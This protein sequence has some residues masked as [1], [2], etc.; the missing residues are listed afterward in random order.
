MGSPDILSFTENLLVDTML[1][2]VERHCDWDSGD[3]DAFSPVSSSLSPQSNSPCSVMW[4]M[5][6]LP[7]DPACKLVP[8]ALAHPLTP[9]EYLKSPATFDFDLFPLAGPITSDEDVF[10]KDAVSGSK[11]KSTSLESMETKKAKARQTRDALT[12][13]QLRI[14]GADTPETKRITHNVLERKRRNDLKTSYQELRETIPELVSQDR[15]PTAQIL[16]KAVEYI[17]ALKTT[18]NELLANLAALR[19][20]NERLQRESL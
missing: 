13:A 8:S 19:A 16:Q 5:D 11:R 20:E 10:G 7:L 1:K 3:S 4:H 14:L 9:C 6:S 18:E 12:E 15:A 2:S 17:E